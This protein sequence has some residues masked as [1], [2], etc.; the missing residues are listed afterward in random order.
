MNSKMTQDTYEHPGISARMGSAGSSSSF[1]PCGVQLSPRQAL[2]SISPNV[3][4]KRECSS[5]STGDC[6][7]LPPAMKRARCGSFGTHNQRDIP[8]ARHNLCSPDCGVAHSHNHRKA[9]IDTETPVDT[10][11]C[12]TTLSDHNRVASQSDNPPIEHPIGACPSAD[13]CAGKTTMSSASPVHSD[14]MQIGIGAKTTREIG[15][16][17]QRRVATPRRSSIRTPNRPRINS[18][19]PSAYAGERARTKGK[20]RVQQIRGTRIYSRSAVAVC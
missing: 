6:A 8:E 4:M 13:Q 11:T 17:M 16:R 14:H 2:G 19:S 12:A 5:R 18:S 3:S 10:D 20:T 15:V 9:R 7:S 1:L